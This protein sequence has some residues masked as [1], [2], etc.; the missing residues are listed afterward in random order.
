MSGDGANTAGEPHPSRET[1][2][3]GVTPRPRRTEASGSTCLEAEAAG[4]R[5]PLAVG[6]LMWSQ[7]KL[8]NEWDAQG[9]P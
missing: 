6:W 7:R 8:S 4:M 2:D 9:S 1:E 3:H 5:T